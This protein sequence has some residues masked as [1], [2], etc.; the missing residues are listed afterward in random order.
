[1][2]GEVGGADHGAQTISANPTLR[3]TK[4]VRVVTKCG[5]VVLLHKNDTNHKTIFTSSFSR[6]M[7]E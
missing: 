6:Y 1:M 7:Y 4:V 5:K 2:K 3:D